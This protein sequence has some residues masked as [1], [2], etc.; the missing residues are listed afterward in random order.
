[1]SQ[2]QMFQHF[3]RYTFNLILRYC[4]NIPQ[5]ILFLWRFSIQHIYY[6]R[7]IPINPNKKYQNNY[8]KKKLEK[9]LKLAKTLQSAYYKET[10]SFIVITYKIF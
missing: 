2:V 5:N 8:Y 10:R 9:Q 3:I 6:K 4:F 7:L 1:M